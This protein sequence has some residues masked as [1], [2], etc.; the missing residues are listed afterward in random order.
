MQLKITLQKFC[1][2]Q[3]SVRMFSLFL[4]RKAYNVFIL[5]F[6]SKL[7]EKTVYLF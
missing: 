7:I 4:A 6:L 1:K 3:G 2:M 5:K